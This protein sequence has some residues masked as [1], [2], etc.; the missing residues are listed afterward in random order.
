[1][2]NAAIHVRVSLPSVAAKYGACVFRLA[3][4]S[5]QRQA[6]AAARAAKLPL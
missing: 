4:E 3:R 5:G 1:M 2:K 6:V